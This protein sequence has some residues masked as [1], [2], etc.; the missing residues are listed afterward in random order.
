MLSTKKLQ[1]GFKILN[2]GGKEFANYIQFKDGSV[3]LLNITSFDVAIIEVGNSS[4]PNSIYEIKN[5]V[6][7][8]QKD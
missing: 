1:D 7:E 2:K 8:L 4:S 5:N 3:R 6:N